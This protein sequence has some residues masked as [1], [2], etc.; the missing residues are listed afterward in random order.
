M[1]VVLG[2]FAQMLTNEFGSLTTHMNDKDTYVAIAYYIQC[3]NK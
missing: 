3:L 1:K 2:S